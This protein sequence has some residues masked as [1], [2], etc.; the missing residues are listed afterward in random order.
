[1]EVIEGPDN[2]LRH[3]VAGSRTVFGRK[4]AE[5]GTVTVRRYKIHRQETLQVAEFHAL[6]LAEIR[7]RWHVKPEA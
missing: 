1:M 4:E 5:E 7:E 3:Q 2:G 6:L